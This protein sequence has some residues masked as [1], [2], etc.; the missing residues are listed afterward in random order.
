[1]GAATGC[2][3]VYQP[4]SGLHQPVVVD[5]TAPN[6][7]GVGL[8][9]RCVPGKELNHTESAALCR[10][11]GTLLENQGARV[12]TSISAATE[13]DPYAALIE[14]QS[15]AAP[16]TTELSLEL[17]AER[18]HRANNMLSWAIAVG[19]LSLVPAR[20]ESSF[21]QTVTIRDANGFQ[22]VSDTLEGRI[23]HYYGVGAVVG[24]FVLDL[25]WRDKDER[26]S[27]NTA[28]RELSADLYG[29][30]SQM[31]FNARMQAEVLEQASASVPR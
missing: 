13:E 10:R 15:D 21:A 1:M 5:P 2:V 31:M 11:V 14:E 29:R 18:T 30:L 26:L 9:V 7:A 25:L 16:V 22:L 28:K 8:A 27:G 23:V 6:L 3:R 19:T 4:M 24:N 20:L 17:R 12:T